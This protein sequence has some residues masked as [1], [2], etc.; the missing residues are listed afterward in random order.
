MK[1]FDI[2]LEGTWFFNYSIEA[3]SKEEAIEKAIKDMDEESRSIDLYHTN[4][5]FDGEEDEIKKEI[6]VVDLKSG[7][8]IRHHTLQ[9]Y[10]D[11]P[12]IKPSP[13]QS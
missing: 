2:C 1:K 3:N 13:T 4:Q 6:Q 10:D 5:W 8:K 9:G 11:A 7:T 12:W